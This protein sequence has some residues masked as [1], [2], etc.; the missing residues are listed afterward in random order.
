[1]SPGDVGAI[2]YGDSPGPLFDELVRAVAEQSVSPASILV[3]AESV[4]AA[5]AA[6]PMSSVVAFA[7]R[8]DE[9]QFAAGLRAA[10]FT[11]MRWTWLLDGWT[12]PAPGALGALLSA[13]DAFDP[14]PALLM[15]S[16]VLDEEGRLH[17]DAM[18]RHEIFEK[19]RSLQAA[20]RHLVQLRTARH[21]SVLIATATI[22]RFGVPRS[23]LPVGLDMLEWS[24]RLLRRWEDTGYLVP[25]SVAVR[26]ARPA[27]QSRDWLGRARVLSGSA[28][29]PTE[30]LWEAFLLG[31]AIAAAVR[32]PRRQGRAAVGAPGLSPSR[33][34]RRMTGITRTA[35]RLKRR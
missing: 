1:M 32:G 31:E 20:A 9:G 30:K 2:I 29:S 3:P 24:A 33:S 6:A 11:G 34:P 18:P 10:A 26:R 15:V 14:P 12:V 13:V 22:E 17:P 4:E 7:P 21:G 19:E 25:A 16:K 5:H 23:D 27:A 28:W 35:K 8:E